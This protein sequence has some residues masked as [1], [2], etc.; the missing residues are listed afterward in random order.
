MDGE[1]IVLFACGFCLLTKTGN[2]QLSQIFIKAGKRSQSIFELVY[3]R[4][5][6]VIIWK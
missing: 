4:L 5:R 1:G 2:V 3:Y 6:K